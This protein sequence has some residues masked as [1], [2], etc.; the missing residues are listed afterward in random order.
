MENANDKKKILFLFSFC[1]SFRPLWLI[2]L[3]DVNH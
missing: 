1:A 3:P 2:L